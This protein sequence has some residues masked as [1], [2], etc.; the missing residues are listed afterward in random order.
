[1]KIMYSEPEMEL[2]LLLND[3][4]RTSDIVIDDN[5]IG[6]EGGSGDLNN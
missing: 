4:I 2:V 3:V 6:E 1:M 5:D